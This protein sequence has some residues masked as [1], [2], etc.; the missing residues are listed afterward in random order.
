MPDDDRVEIT[1]SALDG[2][3]RATST[4]S[5]AVVAAV[6]LVLLAGLAVWA[7]FSGVGPAAADAGALRTAVE[8]R[9]PGLT[10]AAILITTVGSTVAMAVLA[11]VAGA[12]LWARGRPGDAAFLV[13]TTAAA[14]LVFRSLKIVLDRPRPPVAT[15]VV[16]ETNES[17]PS[18]HA[19]MSIVVIGALV[20][21]A[22]R[23]RA[24]QTRVLL[25]L[26]AAAWVGLVGTTRIYLGVH[27]L[28]DVVAGWAVG[29]AWLTVCAL[30]W[31][32]WRNRVPHVARHRSTV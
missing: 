24:V 25:V 5:W 21:L 7:A 18:G 26:A 31:T 28:S 13:L 22:W 30:V 29:A 16:V 8:A 27:W 3:G 1:G 11:A 20:V 4:R 17:L 12:V 32:W 23:G 9:T 15:R 6:G 14:S 19:T 2:A 10:T